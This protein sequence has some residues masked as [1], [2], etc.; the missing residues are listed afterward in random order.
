MDL[1]ARD[2][3]ERAARLDLGR[4][5]DEPLA[6]PLLQIFPDKLRERFLAGGQHEDGGVRRLPQ[7]PGGGGARAFGA[8][9]DLIDDLLGR[10]WIGERDLIERQPRS[11]RARARASKPASEPAHVTPKASWAVSSGQP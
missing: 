7:A 9:R 10:A 5:I 6:R 2:R 4:N 1:L 8:A 11:V 3:L